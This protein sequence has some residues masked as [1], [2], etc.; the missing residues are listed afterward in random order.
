MSALG[1]S[2]TYCSRDSAVC[3]IHP[4]SRSRP[5]NS[6]KA[7]AVSRGVLGEASSAFSSLLRR[8]SNSAACCRTKACR[9]GFVCEEGDG[10]TDGST[11]R[12]SESFGGLAHLLGVKRFMAQKTESKNTLPEKGRRRGKPTVTS[13]VSLPICFRMWCSCASPRSRNR[14][15]GSFVSDHVVV[16][17]VFVCLGCLGRAAWAIADKMRRAA[18]RGGGGPLFSQVGWT[19][20]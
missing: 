2:C 17:G 11:P 15:K 7:S 6:A 9:S 1:T 5:R 14:A 16:A 13:T 18:C 12:L 4:A 10:P 20:C 3:F 8:P 19:W